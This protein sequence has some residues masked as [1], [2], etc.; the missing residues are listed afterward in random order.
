[1]DTE[2]LDELAGRD[3]A[4]YRTL[5]LLIRQLHVKRIIHA[6]DLVYE[7]RLLMGHMASEV[8]VQPASIAGMAA[9]AARIEAEQPLWSEG[10]A[11]A[12]LY[13]SDS[14]AEK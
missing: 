5:G 10:Q 9:I 12:D 14:S 3:D 7:M 4:L 1:M 13:R 8:P 11:V 6:P 2:Q